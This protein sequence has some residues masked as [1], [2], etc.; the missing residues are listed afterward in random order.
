MMMMM[1]GG[2]WCSKEFEN[3]HPFFEADVAEEGSHPAS[4]AYR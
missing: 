3:P 4:V 1:M 2:E